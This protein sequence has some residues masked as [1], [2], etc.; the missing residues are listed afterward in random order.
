MKSFVRA[1]LMSLGIIFII[2]GIIG[3]FLPILQG[4]LFLIPGIYLL[5]IT[6]TRFK[7][8]LVRVLSRYPRAKRI[9]DTHVDRFEK[10]WKKEADPTRQP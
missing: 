4:I 2:V 8:L 6:S 3:L 5:S 7:A 1:S 9:Y 10:I